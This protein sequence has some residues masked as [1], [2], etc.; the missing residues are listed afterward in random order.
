[1]TIFRLFDHEKADVVA[2]PMAP[3]RDGEEHP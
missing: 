2:Y 3:R 1:M